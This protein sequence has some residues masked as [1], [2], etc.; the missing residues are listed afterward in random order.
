MRRFFISNEQ[1][2]ALRGIG[3]M[4]TLNGSDARHIARV[5][6]I[7]EGEKILVCDMA[8][9]LFVC[10]VTA[11]RTSSEG[12]AVDCTVTAIHDAPT[13]G[14]AKSVLYQALIKGDKMDSVIRHATELGVDAVVPVLCERCVSTPD[15]KSLQNKIARWQKICVEAA[16]QCGRA[17]VPTVRGCL[18]F[19]EMLAD[20]KTLPAP[21]FCYEAEEQ[22]SV[23][24]ILTSSDGPFGF[25]IGPEGGL[26]VAEVEKAHGAGIPTVG[27]GKR[28]LRTET[29][30]LAVLSMILYE[31]SL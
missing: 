13:D 9:R 15:A 10:T 28:I 5:L 2:A 29:A 30:G 12:D 19:D 17:D 18:T 16:K 24:E 26:S 11:V 21:F 7:R 23:R 31:K 4:I 3:S 6:R 8:R 22:T 25:F 20:I 27:L 1:S 14:G